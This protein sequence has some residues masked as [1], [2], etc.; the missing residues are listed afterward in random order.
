MA[1]TQPF[2]IPLVLGWIA[3]QHTIHILQH[4]NAVA[5]YMLAA[6]F[7]EHPDALIF[8]GLKPFMLDGFGSFAVLVK[9]S[10]EASITAR[11]RETEEQVPKALQADGRVKADALM[12]MGRQ[13]RAQ[14]A[15]VQGGMITATEAILVET[16]PSC[17][18]PSSSQPPL[19]PPI[20]PFYLT[21]CSRI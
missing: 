12:H 2:Y 5:P 9:L 6:K 16:R 21:L 7:L 14:T 15:A 8:Q 3:D 19:F 1:L 4:F 18:N 17:P 20:D 11:M 10:V 13:V